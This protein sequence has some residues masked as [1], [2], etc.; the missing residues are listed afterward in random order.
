MNYLDSDIESLMIKRVYDMAGVT[1]SC[2]KVKLNGKNIECKDFNSY[3][4]LYLKAAET[5][6]LPKIVEKVKHDRWEV[7]ASLSDGQ[8]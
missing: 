3:V 5:S 2:V 7:V 8:F 1:P 4:D 6:E